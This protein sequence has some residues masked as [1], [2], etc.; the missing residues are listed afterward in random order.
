MHK[1][2]FIRI[3]AAPF[4]P[5]WRPLKSGVRL[6]SAEIW[7]NSSWPSV[8]SKNSPVIILIK[9][10]KSPKGFIRCFNVLAK[11]VV[12]FWKIEGFAMR[13]MP[14]FQDL[15]E[16]IGC[17]L[18]LR[19]FVTF[20]IF[21]RD[22]VSKIIFGCGWFSDKYGKLNIYY[23]YRWL[24]LLINGESDAIVI[25]VE[26]VRVVRVGGLLRGLYYC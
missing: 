5:I 23:C 18:H 26:G 7:S 8:E 22:G 17:S 25:L 24:V 10:L 15:L 9:S 20:L 3:Q 19:I 14:A 2:A 16:K 11:L 21:S 12:K 13:I 4:W 1:T 6:G